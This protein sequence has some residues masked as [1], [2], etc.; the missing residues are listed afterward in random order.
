MA[1]AQVR[2]EGRHEHGRVADLCM[3]ECVCELNFRIFCFGIYV[4][5][6]CKHVM[7][8]VASLWFESLWLVAHCCTP[9]ATFWL[10]RKELLRRPGR[11]GPAGQPACIR[12]P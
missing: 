9:M 5:L 3:K 1:C 7:P 10:C 8:I 6:C 2:A 4:K 11:H 12:I